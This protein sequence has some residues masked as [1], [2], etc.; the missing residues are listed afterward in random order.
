MH[1]LFS[2]RAGDIKLRFTTS[3]ERQFIIKHLLFVLKIVHQEKDGHNWLRIAKHT[4][5]Y[6]LQGFWGLPLIP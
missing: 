3:K 1:S 5:K 2:I 4:D 6:L